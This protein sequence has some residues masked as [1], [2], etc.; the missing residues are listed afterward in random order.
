VARLNL[1]FNEGSL[2]RRTLL[3]VGTL[4]FGSVAFIALTSFALVSIAKGIVSPSTPSSEGA[5]EARAAGDDE[6]P[7]AG[8]GSQK[9]ARAAAKA[10]RRLGAQRP[11]PTKED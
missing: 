5:S 4:V 8:L 10:R 1:G 7:G 3:H 11:T 9:A 6:A 2:L